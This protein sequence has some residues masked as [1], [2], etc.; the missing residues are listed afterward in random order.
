[1][2]GWETI[3]A[4]VV[5][6]SDADRHIAE[7]DENLIRNDLSDLERAGHLAERKRLY[8]L[9]HPETRRGADGARKQRRPG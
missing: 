1:M 5:T 7:I 9:K 4:S 6:L 2:L 3:P 8:L